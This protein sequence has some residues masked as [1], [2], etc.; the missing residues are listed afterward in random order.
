MIAAFQCVYSA[1]KKPIECKQLCDV[2]DNDDD[3]DDIVRMRNAS[4]F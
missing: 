3:N 2:D 4:L 1:Q